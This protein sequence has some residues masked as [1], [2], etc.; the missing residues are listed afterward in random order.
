MEIIYVWTNSFRN[1]RNI[2]FNL[3]NK[4]DISFDENETSLSISY[5]NNN[6]DLIFDKQI[7][8]I[9]GIIGQNSTGKSNLLD[10]ICLV[11]KSS[12]NTIMFDFII[13]SCTTDEY[14]LKKYHIYSNKYNS[15]NITS[16]TELNDISSIDDFKNLNVVYITNVIDGRRHYFSKDVFDLTQNKPM[17]FNEKSDI[18]LQFKFL[19]SDF[20]GNSQLDTPT[21]ISIST[22]VKSYNSSR[23][24]LLQQTNYDLYRKVQQK[25]KTALRKTSASN[26]MRYSF[27]LSLFTFI[28]IE[29]ISETKNEKRRDK[30]DVHPSN[31]EITKLLNDI[32]ADI[33]ESDVKKMHDNVGRFIDSLFY[34]FTEISGIYKKDYLAI[35]NFERAIPYL[36][37]ELIKEQKYGHKYFY[38]ISLNDENINILKKTFKVF[39]FTQIIDVEWRGISSGH[40]AFLNI[41]A[42]LFSI[43]N[44]INNR[45]SVLLCIDEGDL[46]LHPLWQQEFLNR[47]VSFIPKVYSN[48]IQIILTSHSP[49]LVSDLPRRNLIFLDKE[50]NGDSKVISRE[51]LDIK[52]FGANILDLYIDA[53][54]LK[55]SISAFALE[56]IKKAIK[57]AQSDNSTLKEKEFVK[58]VSEILGDKVI[59]F[60]LNKIL[61]K[62]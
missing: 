43:K 39:D 11:L 57:I 2:G 25:Y 3:S 61:A 14:G 5:N 32:F 16:N 41:F 19:L 40:K 31:K 58:S 52:T 1:I 7:T 59:S 42:Q 27:R 13:V 8:N 46:Y 21:S 24:R 33:D 23:I 48:S 37:P 20:F 10:L 45:P 22:Q 18:Y 53:F 60:K 17:R 44:K 50:S 12:I 15:Q 6:T 51:E 56:K 29:A 4:H 35:H 47:L 54:F 28:L 49:F 36:H 9:T 34:E 62:K 30:Y 26:H 55:G 38:E